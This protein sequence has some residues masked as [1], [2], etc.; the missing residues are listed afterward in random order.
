MKCRNILTILVLTVTLHSTYQSEDDSNPFLDIA[1]SFLQETLA[2]Q[3]GGSGGIGGIAQVIGS[4]MQGD[5]SSTGKVGG[6]S[7]AA[8][9]LS[10]LGS[11]LA[12]A[13]AG[14]NNNGR[15][16]NNQGGG[17]F[18]P[19]M[20]MNVVGMFANM[21][22]GGGRANGGGG[23]GSG[24]DAL[25]SIASTVMQNMNSGNNDEEAA[26]RRTKRQQEGSGAGDALMNMMPLVMQMLNSFTGPEMEKTEHRHKDHAQVLPPFLEQIH[27]MW[28]QFQQSELAQA[29]FTKMG[30]SNVFKVRILPFFQNKILKKAP[31]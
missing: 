14:A 13:A 25:L 9:I 11:L 27:V 21:N 7:G 23:G 10:G 29:L 28:D 16:G 6:D 22:Q 24:M 2:N 5:G 30:L 8:Q 20:I 19:S 18:D 12:N 26:P 3:N 15:E 31:L 1:S 17:G 4:L